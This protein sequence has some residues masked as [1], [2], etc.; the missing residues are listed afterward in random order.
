MSPP[1]FPRRRPWPLLPPSRR[2][3]QSVVDGSRVPYRFCS[4]SKI[5]LRSALVALDC[6]GTNVLLPSYLPPGVVE[7]LHELDVEPR[8][9]RVADDLSADVADAEARLDDETSAIVVVHYFG[10][11]QP[12]LDEIAAL[13]DRHDLALIDNNSHSTLSRRDGRLLG[14]FGDV[15]FTSL[16][17][18]LPVPDGAVLYFNSSRVDPTERLP[19]TGV[20]DR[21]TCADYRYCAGAAFSATGSVGEAALEFVDHLCNGDDTPYLPPSDDPVG[22]YQRSKVR[23]SKLSSTAL[24]RIDPVAVTVNR[25]AAFARWHHHLAGDDRFAPP[26]EHLPTG[27][28]PWFYPVVADDPAALVDSLGGVASAFAW[29]T[30]PSGVE[31]NPEY[32]AEN[33]RA[34]R[35]VLLPAHQDMTPAD[36]DRLAARVR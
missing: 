14:T 19:L 32:R 2:S 34:R 36:V 30:L 5:A 27:V 15:G 28:C 8:F 6:P 9:Y 11:P 21:Y 22:E 16:H 35:L 25:R 18:T 3:V 4:S 13:A 12:R 31:G 24:T 7:P 33:E 10:F 29:P 26:F 23:M 17:K 1:S 20:R